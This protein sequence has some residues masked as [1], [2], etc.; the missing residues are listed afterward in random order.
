MATERDSMDTTSVPQGSDPEAPEQRK[1][2]SRESIIDAAR[3]L[4]EEQGLKRLTMRALGDRLGVQ[5]MAL[6]HYF[7]SK[8]ELLQAISEMSASAASQFGAFFDDMDARGATPQEIVVGLGLRYIQFAEEHPD[9]FQLAFNTLP[10]NFA[11]WEEFVTARS[12]FTIPQTAVQTGID[13][14]AF[15]E[16]SGYGRDEMAFSFWALVHG[17]AVLRATRLRDLDAD[18][19]RIHRTVLD[20][21][22][23]QFEGNAD[24]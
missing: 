3:E 9:Q 20:A 15:H 14:G 13:A 21:L 23:R 18:F 1:P 7:A 12:N 2:L 22:V 10:M 4:V 11:T 17:L 24:S 8:D 19:D 5:A 6:Y 16:R